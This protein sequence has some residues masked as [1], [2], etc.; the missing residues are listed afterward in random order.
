ME[1][2]DEAIELHQNALELLPA[3]HTARSLTLN[4]LAKALRTR[5]RR[6]GDQADLDQAILS[7]RESLHLLGPGS[8]TS[9]I[10]SINLGNVLT[11]MYLRTQETEYLKHSIASFRAAAALGPAGCCAR[12]VAI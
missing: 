6:R 8:P 3:P 12:R 4:N 7:C 5:F 2:L 11:D 1:D 9:C 10:V